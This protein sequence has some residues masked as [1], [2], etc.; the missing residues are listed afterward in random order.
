M[1]VFSPMMSLM[2]SI[3]TSPMS[4]LLFLCILHICMGRRW[5]W[6]S[7][8]FI[9]LPMSPRLVLPLSMVYSL[10]HVAQ[11][12]YKHRFQHLHTRGKV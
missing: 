7:S 8:Q 11:P 6:D 2:M 9:P 10:A 5:A 12:S 4:P 1:L 3:L